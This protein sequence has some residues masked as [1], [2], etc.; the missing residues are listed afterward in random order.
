MYKLVLFDLDGT[1]VDTDLLVVEGFLHF[2]RK[3]KKEKV[4][5]DV[6]ASFSGPS[7]KD[8]MKKYFPSYNTDDMVQEYRRVTW[9]LYD[10]F[11]ELYDGIREVLIFLQDKEIK[12]GIVTSKAREATTK[13]L[14]QLCIEQFF[15]YI[16]CVDEV[17]NPKPNPEGINKA[18]DFFKISKDETIYV[19][20]AITD[21]TT[22]RNAKVKCCLVSWNL[23]GKHKD[24]KPD[25]YVDNYLELMGVIIN[26][27]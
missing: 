16:I 3:Y 9:P 24:I 11:I 5:L 17:K 14:S 13:T 18:I 23:R 8:S 27:K 4:S 20:D 10:T 25:Y 26:G 21:L 15:D 12:I 1:L 6:L 22:A 7:L 2:F 19:G